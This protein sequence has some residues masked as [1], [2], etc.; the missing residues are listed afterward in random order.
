MRTGRN[1]CSRDIA[2]KN[3]NVS[4]IFFGL[5]LKDMVN[6]DRQSRRTTIFN[7]YKEGCNGCYPNH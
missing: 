2:E 5:I 4:N 3:K 6:R 7:Y 1:R